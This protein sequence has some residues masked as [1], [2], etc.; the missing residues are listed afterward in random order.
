MNKISLSTIALLSM[1]LLL[2]AG[3]C[4]YLEKNL[5]EYGQS[6]KDA[7]IKLDALA[8]KIQSEDIVIPKEKLSSYFLAARNEKSKLSALID[9][10]RNAWRKLG[11]FLGLIG[12]IQG[13]IIFNV[14][15]KSKKGLQRALMDDR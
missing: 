14:Y 12:V 13:V 4:F 6:T 15:V 1:F 11:I 5:V 7:S 10:E 2:L 8:D 9:A 3:G